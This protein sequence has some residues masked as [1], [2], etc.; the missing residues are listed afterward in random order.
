MKRSIPG[1]GRRPAETDLP[2]LRPFR[3]VAAGGADD[4]RFSR[5]LAG[6]PAHALL[7]TAALALAEG[8]SFPEALGFA[9]A[10]AAL[11]VSRPSGPQAFP[12]RSEVDEMMET[13]L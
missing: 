1:L 5:W 2:V 13:S 6:L 7:V 12:T 3:G 9:S 10:A 11:K 4:L 8:L